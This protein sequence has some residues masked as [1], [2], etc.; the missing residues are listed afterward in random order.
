MAQAAAA[1][2]W[3]YAAGTALTVYSTL[4]AA[5]AQA[6]MEDRRQRQLAIE[7]KSAEL[8][9]RQEENQ[10]LR[11]LTEANADA[12]ASGVGSGILDPF[13]SPSLLALRKANMATAFKDI[14]TIQQNLAIDRARIS[15]EIAISRKNRKAAI[16]GGIL[17][18]AGTLLQAGLTMSALKPA[19]GAKTLNVGQGGIN[20]ELG[21]GI[22]DVPGFGGGGVN[23]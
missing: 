17:Q 12:I 14:K 8:A 23:V 11:E 20:T 6:Q 13:A 16:R 15:A 4:D 5:S 9:A 19:G 10:R 1:L 7:G 2:P 22:L 3:L 21:T 18:A